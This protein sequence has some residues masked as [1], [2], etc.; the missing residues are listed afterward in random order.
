MRKALFAAVLVGSTG[1]AFAQPAVFTDLGQIDSISNDYNVADLQVRTSLAGSTINWYRFSI[2]QNTDPN[3]V[4]FDIDMFATG[5]TGQVDSE[6]GV[7][8]FLGNLVAND[9]DDGHSLRSALTFG[10]TTPR[11][12]PA[13]PFGFTNGLAAN[14]R[15]G[16]LLGGQHYWLAVGVFNTTFG[17]SNWDVTSTGTAQGDLD[18]NFRTDSVPEPGTMALLGLGAA[19]LLRKRRKA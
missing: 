1:Y 10:N 15:D 19:A 8:D 13:D 9:D 3:G 18:I 12:M 4:Y 17:A 7:Y 14:G 11:T 6:I 2:G 5:S 16:N